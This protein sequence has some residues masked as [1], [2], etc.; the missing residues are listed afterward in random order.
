MKQYME[1]D[2]MILNL[3]AHEIGILQTIGERGIVA[4]CRVIK[5]ADEADNIWIAEQI[6]TLYEQYYHRVAEYVKEVQ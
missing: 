6:K 1:D 4:N 5:G 2:F 3:S